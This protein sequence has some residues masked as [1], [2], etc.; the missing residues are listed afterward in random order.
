[1]FKLATSFL[2]KSSRALNESVFNKKV[3]DD[4]V[5]KLN[6]NYH[7]EEE[8]DE[9]EEEEEE[10]ELDLTMEEITT[11]SPTPPSTPTSSFTLE[12]I[13]DLTESWNERV[14]NLLLIV[15]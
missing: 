15:E 2:S 7:D 8:D 6:Y 5:L 13:I 3:A 12:D 1:M 9:Q 4:E 14:T 11:S 10:E